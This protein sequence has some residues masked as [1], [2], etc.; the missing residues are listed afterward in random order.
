MYSTERKFLTVKTQKEN[1][2][3]IRDTGTGIPGEILSKI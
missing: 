3:E 2:F 1:C